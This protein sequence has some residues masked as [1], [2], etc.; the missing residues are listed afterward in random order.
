[1]AYTVMK[2]LI[3]NQN[4]KYENGMVTKEAYKSWKESTMKKLDVYF[5]VNRLTQPE[6]EELVDMLIS[7]DD[8]A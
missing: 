6:Y 3:T 8:L 7:D 1:M 5:A 2:K 4:A